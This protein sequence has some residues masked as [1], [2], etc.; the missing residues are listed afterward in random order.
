MLKDDTSRSDPE[1]AIWNERDIEKAIA[2]TRLLYGKRASVAAAWYAL[3]ARCDGRR[4][5]YR[6][7]F[8]IF[9]RLRAETGAAAGSDAG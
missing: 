6:F 1:L 7:W 8:G 4:A 5:D 9:E 3:A 2:A